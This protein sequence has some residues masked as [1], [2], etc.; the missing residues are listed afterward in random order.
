MKARPLPSWLTGA[1]RFQIR[2][3][4]EQTMVPSIDNSIKTAMAMSQ[5]T[6]S[7]VGQ[8]AQDMNNVGLFASFVQKIDEVSRGVI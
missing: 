8:A 3:Q 5:D 6:V 4:G 2:A 1:P 7:T